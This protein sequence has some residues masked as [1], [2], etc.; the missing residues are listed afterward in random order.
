M[1]NYTDPLLDACAIT[2]MHRIRDK[3]IHQQQQL[4]I[5][6]LLLEEKLIYSH[7]ILVQHNPHPPLTQL[8][9]IKQLIVDFVQKA[10]QIAMQSLER[11]DNNDLKR[12]DQ[13][14]S[15]SI[16]LLMLPNINDYVGDASLVT[17]LKILSFNNL[18]CLYKQKKKYGVAMRTIDFAVKLEEEMLK[19]QLSEQKYDIIP[20]FLNKA[21]V[22]S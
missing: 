8:P 9:P 15:K 20:T 19:T 6:C 13:L 17:K 10:N 16:S 18:S 11:G 3:Y 4:V 1:E 21:A 2:L 14:L 12:Y 22:Y 5:P 7:I